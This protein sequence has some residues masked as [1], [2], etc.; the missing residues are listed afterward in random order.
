MNSKEMDITHVTKGL[1]N[2]LRKLQSNTNVIIG[3]KGK[4][5]IF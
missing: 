1:K 3:D 4:K 5:N 2:K